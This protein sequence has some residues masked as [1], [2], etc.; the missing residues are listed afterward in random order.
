MPTTSITSVTHNRV[1]GQPI[2]IYVRVS[3]PPNM[4]RS[5]TPTGH[6]TVTDGT[7][8]CL[9]TLSG[10]NGTA[11]G[12][13][14]VTEKTA[15]DHSLRA[16]YSGDSIFGSGSVSGLTAVRVSKANSKTILKISAI[17]VAY[18][19]EQ[20]NRLSV[21]VSP[22]FPGVTPSGTVEVKVSTTT[23]CTIKLS[24]AHGSCTMSAANLPAGTHRLV[25]TYSGSAGFDNSAS[26]A[27]ILTV[28]TVPQF[29]ELRSSVTVIGGAFGHAVAISGATAI[30]GAWRQ[31]NGGGAYVFIKTATGWRQA[32][33]L[34]GYD[35]V[36]NDFFGLSVSI[37]GNTAIVGAPFHANHAGRA[38]VF[39]RTAVGWKEAAELKGSD[40]VADDFF[41]LS[42]SISGNT[43]VVGAIAKDGNAGRAYVFTK[44]GTGWKQ[45]AELKGYDTVAG[46]EF[47]WSVA[48]SGAA[49]VVGA[50]YHAESAGGTYV[51]TKTV[52][53]WKQAA[54]LKGSDTVAGDKFGRSVAIAGTTAIVGA[55]GHAK[56]AGRAYVFGV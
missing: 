27:K 34:K 16:S 50:V 31:S 23:L 55:D 9:A 41:G 10:S 7:R 49:A 35:T 52:S 15:G 5:L 48:V 56:N 29:A 32:A 17:K 36:A 53:G 13:C 3:A 18:G 42:V 6:V 37:S 44:T 26:E 24:A 38:Y 11:S 45:A 12:K 4:T 2:P 21:T 28:T 19:D 25:A 40:T 33:E 14:S 39:T 30:V 22:E 20:V 46:D 1:V 54:E 47:G 8:S 51:F 43:T